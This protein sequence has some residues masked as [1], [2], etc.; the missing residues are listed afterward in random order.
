MFGCI[1]AGNDEVG[2]LP[3]E[4]E[5]FVKGLPATPV[6]PVDQPERRV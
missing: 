2:I 6:P 3:V 5:N 1:V 4:I